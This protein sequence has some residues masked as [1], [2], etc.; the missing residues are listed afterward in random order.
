M[1]VL[2]PLSPAAGK[3]RVVLPPRKVYHRVTLICCSWHCRYHTRLK[4]KKR[5][6]KV[7]KQYVQH[8]PPSMWTC[9]RGIR[10]SNPFGHHSSSFPRA[11]EIS[12]FSS[13]LVHATAP[14]ASLLSLRLYTT[15]RHRRGRSINYKNVCFSLVLLYYYRRR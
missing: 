13:L 15:W 14:S 9:M 7:G 10:V 2:F 5:R 8:C 11:T 1:T 3:R 6:L 12:R 4:I